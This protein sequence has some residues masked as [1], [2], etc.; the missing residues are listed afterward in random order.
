MRI[1]DFSQNV[2]LDS[3]LAAQLLSSLRN[4]STFTAT[5][6]VATGSVWTGGPPFLLSATPKPGCTPHQHT[7]PPSCYDF[8]MWIQSL[9]LMQSNAVQNL[10]LSQRCSGRAAPT[11][12]HLPLHQSVVDIP[13]HASGVLVPLV[14]KCHGVCLHST[15][16]GRA[17]VP[18]V[19]TIPCHRCRV[20]LGG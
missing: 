18:S 1:W 3:Y 16:Q 9:V 19:L 17:G 6:E 5:P 14:R 2:S 15:A 13:V 10:H 7:G 4:W 11:W 12:H 20:V 8:F